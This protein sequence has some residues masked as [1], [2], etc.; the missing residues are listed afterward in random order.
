MFYA[1]PTARVILTAKISLDDSVLDENKFGL[2][3]S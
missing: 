3:Q 1:V 2:F